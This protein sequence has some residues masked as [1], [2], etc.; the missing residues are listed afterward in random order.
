MP[1]A[2]LTTDVLTRAAAELADEEGL[3]GVTLAALARRFGVKAPSLYAHVAGERDL[4]QRIAVLALAELADL[5]RD[6]IA[7]RSGREA[8]DALGRAHRDYAVAHPGR[9][10]ATTLPLDDDAAAASAAP[11]HAA[12]S[13]AV[14]RSYGLS[15][16]DETHAVRLLGATVR[17]WTDLQLAG[18]FARSR[19]SAERSWRRAVDGLDQVFTAWG[20]PV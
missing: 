19:P 7:G 9:H 12:L 18:G 17:G 20:S 10:A 11:H 3:G 8:I 2:G 5:V 16:P 14:L 1:R 4:K 6:A 13:R 15:E